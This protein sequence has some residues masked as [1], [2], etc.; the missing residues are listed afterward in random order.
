LVTVAIGSEDE[1]ESGPGKALAEQGAEG[2]PAP[3][4]SVTSAGEKSVSCWRDWRGE[5]HVSEPCRCEGI[6]PL[7][8]CGLSRDFWRLAGASW[9]AIR[10]ANGNWPF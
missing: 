1:Q 6:A 5:E 9:R 2:Y 3:D 10:R 8:Y 4:T 7:L